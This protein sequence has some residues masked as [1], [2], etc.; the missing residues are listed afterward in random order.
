MAKRPNEKVTAF[1]L[2][3]ETVFT[4]MMTLITLVSQF[5]VKLFASLIY[6][7]TYAVT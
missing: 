5:T 6:W 4:F 3:A 7:P 2:L 1:I